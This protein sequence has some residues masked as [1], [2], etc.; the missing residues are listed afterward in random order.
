IYYMEESYNQLCKSTTKIKVGAIIVLNNSI[1]SYGF[2]DKGIHAERMAIENAKKNGLKLDE[3]VLFTTLEPCIEMSDTQKKQCCA[4]L[5][6]ESGIKKVYI[7]SYDNNVTVNRKGWKRLKDKGITI[8]DYKPNIREKIKK[9]NVV[10]ENFFE[11]GIGPKGGAKLYHKNGAD[12]EIQLSE[13]D[14][15]SVKIRFTRCGKNCVYGYAIEPVKFADAIYAENFD[16]IDDPG[17]YNFDYTAKIAT[18]GIGIFSSP[19][20]YILVKPVE[21]ESGPDYG[22]KDYF[23]KFDYEVRIRN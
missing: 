19:E 18:G 8:K 12:F 10:F 15:R 20:A 16:D 17:A 4:D 3:A 21:I 7:G 5:I 1:I 14:T 9:E 23:V 22:D 13:S 6:I 11:K 2:R